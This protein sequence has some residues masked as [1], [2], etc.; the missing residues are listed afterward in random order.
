MDAWGGP[1]EEYGRSIRLAQSSGF[2]YICGSFVGTCDFDPGAG[3]ENHA[4]AGVYDAFLSCL[5]T[6]GIYQW[7]DTWGGED[8]EGASEVEIDQAG[9]PTVVGFYAATV[10]FDPGP[11]VYNRISNGA[12]DCF[13]SNFDMSGD[14]NWVRTWGGIDWDSARAIFI[15]SATGDILVTGEFAETVDMD[16]GPGIDNRVC[17]GA[18]DAFLTKFLTG[19]VW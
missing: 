4:S 5:D 19:G 13:M 3:V 12:R 2:L 18:Y 11:A 6:S 16:P 9:N 1:S 14:F 10:D 8:Y 17:N 15:N 7:V